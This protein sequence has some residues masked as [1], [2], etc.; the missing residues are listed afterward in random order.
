[1]YFISGGEKPTAKVYALIAPLVAALT[2]ESELDC[3]LIADRLR[4]AVNRFEEDHLV[5]CYFLAAE[6]LEAFENQRAQ[7]PPSRT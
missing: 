2:G 7:R 1:M 4:Q 3:K 6:A 5:V